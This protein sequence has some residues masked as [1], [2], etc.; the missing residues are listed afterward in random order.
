MPVVMNYSVHATNQLPETKHDLRLKVAFQAATTVRNLLHNRGVHNQAWLFYC[1]YCC[2]HC[3]WCYFFS[4]WGVTGPDTSNQCFMKRMVENQCRN[5]QV[6]HIHRVSSL[7]CI[8]ESSSRIK[9]EL[10]F[11]RQ[12]LLSVLQEKFHLYVSASFPDYHNPGPVF[13]W[14]VFF[15][16]LLSN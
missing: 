8:D 6:H 4:W 11:H 16:F 3:C 10:I 2:W 1:C 14:N 9:M 5:S 12:M 7:K 15:F 13:P